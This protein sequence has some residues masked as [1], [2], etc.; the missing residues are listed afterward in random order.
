MRRILL[1]ILVRLVGSTES[2]QINTL[3]Q[4][5]KWLTIRA[6]GKKSIGWDYQYDERERDALIWALERLK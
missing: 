5:M 6:A 1:R 3:T 4:R 2:D